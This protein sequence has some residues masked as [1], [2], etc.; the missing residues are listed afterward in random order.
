MIE[1]FTHNTEP[2]VNNIDASP[3][4]DSE[5]MNQEDHLFYNSISGHLNGLEMNPKSET[6]DKIMGY[7]KNFTQV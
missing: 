2:A 7:S 4:G 1:T 3:V 5:D 6:L